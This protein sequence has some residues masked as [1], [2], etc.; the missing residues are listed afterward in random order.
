MLLTGIL[1]LI[2]NDNWTFRIFDYPRVQKLV[3]CIALLVGWN[4]YGQASLE[5]WELFLPILLVVMVLYLIVQIFPFTPLAKRM[6]QSTRKLEGGPDLHVMVMNVYQYNTDYDKVITLLKNENPD[7]FLLVETDH[8]WA[9]AIAVFK[10]DYPY[11]IE[12][13]LDNTYGMLFYSKNEILSNKI[14]YLVDEDIPSL[15]TLT[16]LP[17]GQAVKIFSIHP[18]PPVPQENPRSTERDAEILL[19][20]KMVKAY[21]KPAIVIGD[22]NDV[23]WSYTSNLFLKTSGLLDPRRGRG[24]YSTFH[25]KYFFL[26][27]PLDHIFVTKHFTL[28]KLTVH[29][30]VGSDHFPISATFTLDRENNNQKME[31]DPEAEHIAEEKIEDGLAE[32][33]K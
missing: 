3:I 30:P 6:V 26:R 25:A 21:Q 29:G 23:G 5:S 2:K 20:G 16:R 28:D 9:N 13:P 10:K 27:W 33:E 32:N 22:L 11:F 31:S 12:I 15:E 14:N 8:H 19:V 18:M 1:P 17:N 7:L 24:M 4:F